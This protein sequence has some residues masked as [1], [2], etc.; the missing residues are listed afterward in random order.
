[1]N[2][3]KFS[4][5]AVNAMAVEARKLS[6]KAEKMNTNYRSH[7]SKLAELSQ[8]LEE[9]TENFKAM[10]RQL[11]NFKAHGKTAPELASASNPVAKAVENA[12]FSD[13]ALAEAV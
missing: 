6:D 9:A 4:L 10:G 12:L 1:M 8:K 7:T 3:S 2:I 13:A 5:E 11:K